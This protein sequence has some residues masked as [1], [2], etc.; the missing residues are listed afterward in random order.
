[1][2]V[3]ADSQGQIAADVRDI[4]V[5]DSSQSAYCISPVVSDQDGTLYFKN[6]SGHIFA[7]AKKKASEPK[8]SLFR[9]IIEWIISVFRKIKNLFTI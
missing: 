5:P 9:R 7:I 6:D 2:C 8:K 4:Y 3:L 1:M